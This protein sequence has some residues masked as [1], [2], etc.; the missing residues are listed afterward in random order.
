MVTWKYVYHILRKDK[1]REKE[2][3][4]YKGLKITESRLQTESMRMQRLVSAP[5]GVLVM[6]EMQM[7]ARDRQLGNWACKVPCLISPGHQLEAPWSVPQT[8]DSAQ[9]I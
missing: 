1:E 3:Q 9:S 2:R 5:A 8:S 6:R 4:G 7:K